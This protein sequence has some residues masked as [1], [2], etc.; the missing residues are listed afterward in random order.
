M[1][2]SHPRVLNILKGNQGQRR[3]LGALAR[4]DS[5]INHQLCCRER[6]CS[7]SVSRLHCVSR[8]SPRQ[9]CHG[10]RA[11]DADERGTVERKRPGKET[12][13][14]ESR[15]REIVLEYITG[16]CENPSDV[17][18]IEPRDG[19]KLFLICWLKN[20]WAAKAW[21]TGTFTICGAEHDTNWI[22]NYCLGQLASL[23]IPTST[24]TG[25]FDDITAPLSG[26]HLKLQALNG[27]CVG[28]VLDSVHCVLPTVYRSIIWHETTKMFQNVI[29]P[30]LCSLCYDYADYLFNSSSRKDV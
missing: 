3:W 20:G 11:R 12:I 19:R 6:L 5:R 26:S 8:K 4:R 14:T 28:N 16:K 24:F 23:Q 2:F 21:Q 15:K 29:M 10:R 9:R 18:N 17:I 25:C 27:G 7:V 1:W 13:V 22:L 30:R